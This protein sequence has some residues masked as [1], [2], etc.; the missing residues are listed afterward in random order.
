MK[1]EYDWTR[2]KRA[3]FRDL[4]PIDELDRR[5][6]VRITIMIDA[7]GLQHFKAKA[8]AAG[9]A[10]YQTQIN[11]ALRNTS[12]RAPP[13]S[14]RI[15]STTRTA[16]RAWPSAWPPTRRPSRPALGHGDAPPP[17]QLEMRVE[18]V[19]RAVLSTPWS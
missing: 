15:F 3:S 10:P 12:P 2:A 1:K 18:P 8:A 5:T 6:K 16:S 11:R 9:A 4:P 17:L 19:A 14:G 13:D 7:D